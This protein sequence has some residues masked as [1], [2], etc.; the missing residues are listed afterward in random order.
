MSTPGYVEA[1][2]PF[3]ELVRAAME[4]VTGAVHGPGNRAVVHHILV[5]A[6]P[7][8][9]GGFG[10]GAALGGGG[11]NGYLVGYVPGK[12]MEPYPEGMAKK[13]TWFLKPPR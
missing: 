12:R 8:G 7:P 10:G 2:H 6:V 11:R 13:P 5:F 9:G 3:Q 1:G 4:A